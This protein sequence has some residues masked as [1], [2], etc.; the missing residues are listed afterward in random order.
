MLASICAKRLGEVS[1]PRVD[2]SELA[3]PSFS[4]QIEI[5]ARPHEL[6]LHAE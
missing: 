5:E 6:I 4:R 1:V 3:S 2:R